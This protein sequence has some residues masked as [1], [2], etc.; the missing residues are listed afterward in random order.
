MLQ[1][2]DLGYARTMSR[3]AKQTTVIGTFA[4]MA[5]EVYYSI[6]TQD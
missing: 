1:I 6:Q 4:W 3:T 2:V 5:P